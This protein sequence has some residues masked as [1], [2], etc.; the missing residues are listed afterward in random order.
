MPHRG[1]AVPHEF[2]ATQKAALEAIAPIRPADGNTKA[3]NDTLFSA[4]RSKAGRMLPEYYLVYFLLVEFL[5]FRD[6][7][8]F[9]K[10]AWSVPIDFNGKAYLIEHRKFGV[11][12]FVQDAE[13]DEPACEEIVKLIN[14]GVKTAS[15]FFAWLAEQA[16]NDSKLNVVNE[17]R[18]LFSRYQYFLRTYQKIRDQ[19]ERRAEEKIVE[20][21]TGSSGAKWTTVSFPGYEL[22]RESQWMAQAAIDA[23]FGW[24]EHVFIHIAILTGKARTGSEVKKLAKSSWHEKFN[25]ALDCRDDRTKELYEKLYIIKDQMRNFMAH[26]A[27]GK[28]GEAFHFHSGAGAVP[29]LLAERRGVYGVT[30]EGEASFDEPNALAT[31]EEFIAHL[32]SGTR[33][34]A[35]IYIQE[36]GL[37]LLL[38]MANDGTYASAMRSTVEMEEFTHGLCREFDDARNMD[39]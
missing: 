28:R 13:A 31:I 16:V 4:T 2:A 15:P 1:T 12:I 17:S 27:F 3:R 34:P 25:S 5:G 38:T 29:V 32:W 19:A 26:G 18:D 8:R 9:E 6:L 11:G 39:W 7:G 35:R 36:S 30:M 22:R 10:L 23:F 33:A 37:P 24:T 21:H 14:N 20:D